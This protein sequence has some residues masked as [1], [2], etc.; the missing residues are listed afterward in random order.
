MHHFDFLILFGQY[1]GYVW[2]SVAIALLILSALFWQSQHQLAQAKK[3]IS[4]RSPWVPPKI[5]KFKKKKKNTHGLSSQ[6]PGQGVQETTPLLSEYPYAGEPSKHPAV[7]S[8][9]SKI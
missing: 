8:R 2:G 7:V 1:T 6:G 3:R 9:A 4:Y 5:F